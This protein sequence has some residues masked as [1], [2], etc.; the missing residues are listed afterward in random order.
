[1]ASFAEATEGNPSAGEWKKDCVAP[2]KDTRI[3][4]LVSFLSFAITRRVWLGE[5][6]ANLWLGTR[7]LARV[8]F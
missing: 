6:G 8:E 5:S 1:M 7:F 3:Q 4:T 2:V